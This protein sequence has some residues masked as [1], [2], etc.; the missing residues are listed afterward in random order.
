MRHDKFYSVVYAA[1]AAAVALGIALGFYQSLSVE[2]RLPQVNLNE[3]VSFDLGLAPIV[4]DTACGIA[5]R[6]RSSAS[7]LVSDRHGPLSR[8]PDG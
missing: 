1:G 4:E 2:H 6:S 7:A 5:G 3:V 8:D